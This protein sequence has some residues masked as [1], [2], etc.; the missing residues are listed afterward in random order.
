MITEDPHRALT[1]ALSH[2]ER[3]MTSRGWLDFRKSP[4]NFLSQVLRHFFGNLNL[5]PATI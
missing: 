4:G 5:S 1:P 3:E 2:G